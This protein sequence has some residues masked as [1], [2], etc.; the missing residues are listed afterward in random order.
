MA[1]LKDAAPFPPFP[2]STCEL[3]ERPKIS[4][5]RG[6]ETVAAA[7]RSIF[8]KVSVELHHIFFIAF[9]I[10]DTEA[11]TGLHGTQANETIA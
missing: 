7:I 11:C 10:H 5:H 1:F 3:F 6:R 9:I 2:P 8:R 4:T